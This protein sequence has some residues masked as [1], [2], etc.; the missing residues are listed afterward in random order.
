[1]AAKKSAITRLRERENRLSASK[2]AEEASQKSNEA[3][4]NVTGNLKE[5]G[6]ASNASAAQPDDTSKEDPEPLAE[7]KAP[8]VY[9]EDNEDR[10]WR[11]ALDAPQEQPEKLAIPM[12][13][14]EM[15]AQI[16]Q[17]EKQNKENMLTRNNRNSFIDPQPSAQKVEWDDISQQSKG[18]E[19]P[20]SFQVPRGQ[21]WPRKALFD[22]GTSSEDDAFEQGDRSQVPSRRRPQPGKSRETSVVQQRIPTSKTTKPLNE[23]EEAKESFA[24]ASQY[25]L[26]NHAAKESLA[27]NLPKQPQVRRPW[28]NE[29]VQALMEYMD[30]YGCSW[31]AI[32]AADSENNILERRSQ[33]DL[34]DKARNMKYDYLR[35][36]RCDVRWTKCVYGN[37]LQGLELVCRQVL[38]VFLLV[39]DTKTN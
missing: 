2:I 5:I 13:S 18:T 14:M 17:I 38:S 37:M 23:Q 36:V 9:L 39:R 6:G 20:K 29:E 8:A 12:S 35:Y 15:V 32:K 19:P 22:E 10:E 4:K 26:I 31:A 21:K 25:K 24:K 27:R 1:M 11:N 30:E 28:S 7:D 16:R 3:Y 34:K 33:V